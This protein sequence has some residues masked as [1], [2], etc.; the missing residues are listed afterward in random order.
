MKRKIGAAMKCPT[1]ISVVGYTG[2]AANHNATVPIIFGCVVGV[3]LI[4]ATILGL[5]RFVN[6]NSKKNLVFIKFVNFNSTVFQ[7]IQQR[8]SVVLIAEAD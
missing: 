7:L 2:D 3:V 8:R 4:A 5:I 6:F 1:L